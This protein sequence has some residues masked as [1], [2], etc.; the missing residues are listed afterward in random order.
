MPKQVVGEKSQGGGGLA[1][2]TPFG[3]RRLIKLRRYFPCVGDIGLIIGSKGDIILTAQTIFS[4]LNQGD[5]YWRLRSP[6]DVAETP[7]VEGELMATKWKDVPSDI[8]A[9]YQ[10]TKSWD[11]VFIKGTEFKLK[12]IDCFQRNGI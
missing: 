11:V 8:D 3:G 12:I 9:A 4:L 5:R 2:T 7:G 10:S 1:T 6:G